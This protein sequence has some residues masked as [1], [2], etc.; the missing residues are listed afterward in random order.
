MPAAPPPE[1]LDH[2]ALSLVPNLGPRL[3]AALLLHF[4]SIGAARRAT[5]PQLRAVPK[6]GAKLAAGFAE[7]FQTVDPEAEY[8]HLQAVGV[9]VLVLGAADY[10]ARLASIPDA[11]PVLFCQGELL[12][13]DELSVGLVGSRAC[14]PYG[15][16]AAE[17]LAAGLARA[18]W[19]VISGLARGIDGAAHRAALEAGGR[20][21]AVL[22]GGL[23][24][25]YP[26]EHTSLAEAVRGR[27]ALLTET[28]YRQSPQP[29]LFPAR[30]RIIS[31]L[32][33]AV[34]VVEANRG[35]GALI[36]VDHAADQGRD[37]FAVP[38]PIDSPA[39]AGCLELLRTG[40]RL[41]RDAD[42][43]LEDLRGLRTPPAANPAPPKTLF[44][45]PPPPVPEVAATLPP[46]EPL[47]Q[48]VYDALDGTKHAD[49]LGRATGLSAADLAKALMKL[50]LLKRVRRM[51]GNQ[52]ARR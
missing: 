52:Y 35:S 34:V 6:I 17:R 8:R 44:D 21:L 50:E 19:T 20:T 4:G 16:R 27:G 2:L 32:A 42:D 46:L 14:T 39:S 24:A 33:R 51:P 48:T 30:N 1:L 49:E 47:L 25:I 40:A 36:T 43:L 10:P 5:E 13:A 7:A 45:A 3:T 26:P 37:V 15:I 38:G 12:P 11:P 28:P 23:S 22:A 9:R 41:I 18:G 31:G 29:G